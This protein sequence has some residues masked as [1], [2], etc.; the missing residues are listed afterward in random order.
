VRDGRNYAGSVVVSA[1]NNSPCEIL[2]S[3][4]RSMSSAH[5][6]ILCQSGKY[7]VS[8]NLSTNGTFVN[9]EQ[10][11]ARGIELPDD[12]VIKAG[13]TVFK[14]QKI[15]ADGARR[16]SPRLRRTRS[17]ACPTVAK[18]RLSEGNGSMPET[19]ERP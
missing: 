14:F 13:A 6:L 16:P 7:I 18:T 15:H 4:D 2:V 19:G 17:G 10:I 5:F 11:D 1:D 12:A 8:D 9:G 3:E